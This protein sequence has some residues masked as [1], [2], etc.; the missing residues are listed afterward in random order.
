MQ[1][2]TIAT[3]APPSPGRSGVDKNTATPA[4]AANT[5]SS[6][7]VRPPVS[8]ITPIFGPT[9]LP[10]DV[11]TSTALASK[12]PAGNSRSN[13]RAAGPNAATAAAAVVVDAVAAAEQKFAQDRKAFTH[14]QPDQVGAV[15]PAAEPIAF[16]DNP[17]V[18]A[19]QSAIT[20]LQLQRAKAMADM[21]ALSRI[22][23]DALADPAAFLADLQA[24]RV[25]AEGDRLFVESIA[26]E[27]EDESS[28]DDDDADDGDDQKNTPVTATSTAAAEGMMDVDAQPSE[29]KIAA[30]PAA[31]AEAK[32]KR[33]GN[34]SN[35][36]NT[37]AKSWHKLPKPQN[38]VRTPPVNWAQYGVVGESLDK[39]HAEQRAAPTQGTP[40]TLGAGSTF[41][42]KAG[43]QPTG[44]QRRLVGIAAP[45]TPGKDKLDKKGK[46]A[47]R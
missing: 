39:L 36:A 42:F 30:G 33:Q 27:D 18:L 35:K 28:S 43:D 2:L 41:E 9:K 46:G 7:P 44:E 3:G 32:R 8:P 34:K 45:Y 24:G 15:P 13:N 21:Q 4:S 12:P 16:E 26:G 17:D 22:K 6:S 14:A 29:E 19:I 31:A 11:P 5:R 20:I 37:P 38:I 25:R 40:L 23:N 10:G 47:Q 1:G